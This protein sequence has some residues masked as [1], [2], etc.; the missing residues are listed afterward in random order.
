VKTMTKMSF[1]WKKKEIKIISSQRD[2]GGV[3]LLTYC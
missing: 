3:G 1:P 2:R